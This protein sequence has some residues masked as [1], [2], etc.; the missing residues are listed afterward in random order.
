V[1]TV[2]GDMSRIRAGLDKLDL[3][4]ARVLDLY[5]MPVK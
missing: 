5:G 3:G 2:V 1:I 4:G